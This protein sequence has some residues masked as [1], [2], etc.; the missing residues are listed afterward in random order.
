MRRGEALALTW[1][2]VDLERRTLRVVGTLSRVDG[3]LTVTPAK[4][5]RS[6]R[7]IPLSSGAVRVL[8]EL[9]TRQAEDKRTAGSVWRS[10]PCV[11]TT[12]AG[13]PCDPRNALR[14]LKAAAAKAG[15]PGI[16]LHTLRHSTASVMIAN[17]V[18]LKVVYEILGHASIAKT[19]DIYGHVSPDVSRDAVA[20]L[21]GAL[22]A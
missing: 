1:G 22:S 14:A 8:E 12:E 18:P 4:T 3:V 2:D 11:F 15:L 10:T 19:G 5:E 7:T 9:K 21:A 17:G 13:E 6:R 16:G 20:K